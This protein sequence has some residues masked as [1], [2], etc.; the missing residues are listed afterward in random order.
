M[1]SRLEPPPIIIAPSARNHLQT[2]RQQRP[3]TIT[4]SIT[5]HRR[6]SH[7]SLPKWTHRSGEIDSIA[8]EPS[9]KRPAQGTKAPSFMSP[10]LCPVC[11]RS[12]KDDYVSLDC[13]H[14]FHPNCIKKVILQSRHSC[15]KDVS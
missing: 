4:P 2:P 7:F 1:P 10:S 6:T 13:G 12:F 3:S 14:G 9:P 8:E 11:L 15:S 5:S